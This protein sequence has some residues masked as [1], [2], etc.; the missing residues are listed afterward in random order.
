M[1][2]IAVIFSLFFSLAACAQEEPAPS[3]PE[4]P[5][6]PAS[7]PA[8]PPASA[9]AKYRAGEHY[10]VIE[11]P[12][13]TVT[14]GKIEVTEVFWYG[15]SHCF[16]F[17]PILNPWS[18]TLADDVELVKSPAVWRDSMAAHARIFYTAKSMGILDKVHGK[19]FEA[20]HGAERKALVDEKEI[21][22]LF[23][24]LGA[25]P[26]QFSKVYSSF[27]VSSQVQ[28]AGSRAR[29]FMITGTPE[30][31]VGGRF[32]ISATKAGGQKGMLDVADFL[33]EQIRE[34][35]I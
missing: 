26:E 17:E 30:L 27:S 3:A 24:A 8:S 14:P 33:I 2:I 29:S 21:K 5:P 6:A 4:S 28:Q 18:K 11:V 1:R 23:V 9:P 20:M 25:D 31:V 34:K 15:C 12:V 13:K 22:A 19:V 7:A 16:A 32:R 10:E 35:K